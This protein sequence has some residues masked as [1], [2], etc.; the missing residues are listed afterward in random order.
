VNRGR[1]HYA[2]AI[3]RVCS[4]SRLT[5]AA[6]SDVATRVAET[7]YAA[8]VGIVLAEIERIV[9]ELRADLRSGRGVAVMALLKSIDDGVRGLCTELDLSADSAWSCQ[10][11]TVRAE[12]SNMLKSVIETMPGHVR[13]LL[14]PRATK[15]IVPTA[16]LDIGDVAE[17]D[18]LIEFVGVCRHYA[19]ELAVNTVTQRA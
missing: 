16:V 2:S 6:E 8:A 5:N 9:S 3:R 15:E 17:V 13:R 12:I 14:R 1:S 4:S 19:N 7:P 10:L 18:S 11:A